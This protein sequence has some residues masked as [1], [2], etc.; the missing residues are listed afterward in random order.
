MLAPSLVERHYEIR[1]PV[2]VL[3][4]PPHLEAVRRRTREIR[5]I[6]VDMDIVMV[7]KNHAGVVSK[8]RCE[9]LHDMRQV[10]VC[11]GRHIDG[12]W[13]L[14]QRNVSQDYGGDAW[15]A[16]A[17][18][19]NPVV[20]VVVDAAVS[21]RCFN[22]SAFRIHVYARAIIVERNVIDGRYDGPTTVECHKHNAT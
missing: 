12:I 17:G 20:G 1:M 8:W 10:D 3:L 22:W 18:S 7:D 6:A 9:G 5:S 2:A 14:I 21:Y 11:T 4:R 13:V 16:V 19:V 15:W